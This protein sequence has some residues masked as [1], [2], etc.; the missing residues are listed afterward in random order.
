MHT[1][2]SQQHR[3]LQTLLFS[4]LSSALSN[5]CIQTA[6]VPPAVAQASNSILYLGDVGVARQQYREKLRPY[7]I[8]TI[9]PPPKK[10]IYIQRNKTSLFVRYSYGGIYLAPYFTY[11]NDPP[12]S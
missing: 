4:S 8:N 11:T 12:S 3:D 7:A 6:T 5:D 9:Y 2:R 1:P 10:Y